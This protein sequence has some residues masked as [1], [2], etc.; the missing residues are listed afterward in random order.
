MIYA[1]LGDSI[2]YGYHAT[3]EKKHFVCRIQASLARARR[4]SLFTVAKPGWTSK[5]LLKSVKSV[6]KCIWDES[7]VIT[8]LVGGNDLIRVSPWLL[9][10]IT[11]KSVPVADKLADNLNEIVHVVKR[12]YNKILIGTV[13]NPFPNS[14]SA[15]ECTGILNKSIRLVAFRENLILVDL[16]RAFRCKE[17]QFIEGYKNGQMRD[18]KIH[19]NPIHPNDFGHYCISQ[20]FLTAYRAINMT[21]LR[22]KGKRQSGMRRTTRSSR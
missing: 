20:A 6:P 22:Q 9:N 7:G 21:K 4:V 11:S 3:T 8:V 10:G 2:T 15:E 19:H 13:Y 16:Y 17:H 5:Q 12:P 14:L 1:A 18:F